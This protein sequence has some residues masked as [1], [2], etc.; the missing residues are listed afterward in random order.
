MSQESISFAPTLEVS[1]DK[2]EEKKTIQCG[3]GRYGSIV[4]QDKVASSLFQ[5]QW[6]NAGSSEIKDWKGYTFCMGARHLMI[7]G[8]ESFVLDYYVET[9]DW[10][11][12][13]N[14]KMIILADSNKIELAPHESQTDVGHGSKRACVEIGFYQITRDDL[15]LIAD[16]SSVEAKVSGDSSY[17]EFNDTG[18]TQPIGVPAGSKLQM[19][20]QIILDAADGSSTYKSKVTATCEKYH[21]VAKKA[22]EGCFIAT[23]SY[24]DYNDPAV[25]ELRRFRDDTLLGSAH[26]KH[27]V[28]FYY[29]HGPR[30]AKQVAKSRI[31][32]TAVRIMLLDPMR[33]LI[34]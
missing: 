28:D 31:A 33:A 6:F 1:E 15:K 22:S 32:R 16:A 25:I 24:G 20:C 3:G 29:K 12:L 10:L 30:V 5:D 7:K 2:F 11:F 4:A 8:T 14:G 27:F 26:G 18:E 17:L 34:R 23:A 13:R 9:G 19:L 21:E